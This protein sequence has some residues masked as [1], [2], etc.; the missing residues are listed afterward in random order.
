MNRIINGSFW[1]IINGTL[2]TYTS[3]L[4][5]TTTDL[6]SRKLYFHKASTVDI[7]VVIYFISGN[8]TSFVLKTTVVSGIY[9]FYKQHK[10]TLPAAM[11][12][13]LLTTRSLVTPF[14]TQHLRASFAL[15][16][17]LKMAWH[18]KRVVNLSFVRVNIYFISKWSQSVHQRWAR[19]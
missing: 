1:N 10:L 8:I 3:W 13:T 19:G 14:L 12:V 9:F 11:N 2:W 4:S 17:D 6:C 16:F 7:S 15:N 5:V 18:P